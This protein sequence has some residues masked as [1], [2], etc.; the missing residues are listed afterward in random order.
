MKC[1]DCI[2]FSAHFPEF[3]NEPENPGN[4]TWGAS[5]S[6]PYAWRYSTREIVGVENTTESD[7]DTFCQILTNLPLEATNE[8]V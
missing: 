5:R 6:I 4:C 7:C 2:Y 1:G 8:K 3:N